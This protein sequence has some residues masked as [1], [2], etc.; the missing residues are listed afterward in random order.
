MAEVYVVSDD[1]GWE[2][3]HVEGVFD[4]EA[5]A[6]AYVAMVNG[7]NSLASLRVDAFP[8]NELRATLERGLT[9]VVFFTDSGAAVH[10]MGRVSEDPE[11]IEP[12]LHSFDPQVALRC[13]TTARD[14]ET[15]MA[16]CAERRARYV[17]RLAET[18]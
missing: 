17:A 6:N 9:W 2:G 1:S 5:L 7:G 3:V 18:S 11:G 16:V 4:D 8:L 13:V 12:C 15:A 10:V 14:R